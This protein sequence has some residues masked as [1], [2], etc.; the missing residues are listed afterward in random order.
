MIT[1]VR[2]NAQDPSHGWSRQ[3][4][5]LPRH[6]FSEENLAALFITSLLHHF[7]PTSTEADETLLAA[8]STPPSTSTIPGAKSSNLCKPCREALVNATVCWGTLPSGNV[9]LEAFVEFAYDD[10][11]QKCWLYQPWLELMQ[12][13]HASHCLG[14]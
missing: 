12:D 7:H 4:G 1:K 10:D 13:V 14:R 9:D 3:V 6:Q 11:P 8:S 2:G 5:S